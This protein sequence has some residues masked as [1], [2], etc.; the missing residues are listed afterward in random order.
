MVAGGMTPAQVLIAA[1]R[2]NARWLKLDGRLGAIKV[3]LLADLVAMP[4]DP[5][6]DIGAVRHVV[7]VMKGGVVARAK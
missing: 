4:G 7:F 3:G 2:G 1:T 5:T 6:V